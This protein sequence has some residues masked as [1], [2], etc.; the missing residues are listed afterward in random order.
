MHWI[1]QENLYS[2]ATRVDL[3]RQVA[4][5]GEVGATYQLVKLVP[6]FGLFQPEIAD[7]KGRVIALGSTTMMKV[8]QER[9]WKPGIF[10]NENFRFEAWR[11]GFGAENLFNGD[12]VVRRFADLEITSDRFIRPC[13]DL[14]AFTGFVTT[15][16][17][18]TD[19][20]Q[21]VLAGEKSTEFTQLDADTMIVAAEPRSIFREYRVFVVG[22]KAISASLYR[23]LDGPERSA[24]V[25][26]DVY[27]F[28]QA[29]VDRWNPAEAY[30]LDIAEGEEGLK[31]LEINCFNG[32]GSYACDLVKIYGA[33]E[34]LFAD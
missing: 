34:R 20:K 19:W 11:S 1:L 10:I 23:T 3:D 26:S 8:V 30:A 25:D 31:V 13:E 15:P 22:G 9:G 4:A 29:M 2:E 7:P 27:A 5:L 16:A 17:Q 14:K 32:A 33:L 21:R 12:A 18:W 6:F 28:A 24:D